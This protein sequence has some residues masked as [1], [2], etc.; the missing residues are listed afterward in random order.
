MNR[1]LIQLQKTNHCL[2]QFKVGFL[3]PQTIGLTSSPAHAMPSLKKESNVELQRIS[4]SSFVKNVASLTAAL[5][6]DQKS[7]FFT[8]ERMITAKPLD[9]MW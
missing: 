9:A 8:F 2:E 6:G 1:S 3:D 5:H 4:Q 7:S